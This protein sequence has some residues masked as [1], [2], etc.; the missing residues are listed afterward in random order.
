M[1]FQHAQHSQGKWQQLT[2][3]EQLGNIGGEVSRAAKQKGKNEFLFNAAG[4]RALELFDLTIGDKRWSHRLKELSRA[5]EL[6]CDTAF[7]NQEYNA[8]LEHL[9]QYFDAFA[10]KARR[11]KQYHF[12]RG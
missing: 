2:L 3:A 10:L 5:R 6:F 1:N 12:K 4:E 8:T 11:D 9:V 7:G